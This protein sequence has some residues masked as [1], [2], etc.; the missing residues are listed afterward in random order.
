[1]THT[2]V[3]KL[4]IIGLWNCLTGAKPC[5]NI[6]TWTLRNKLYQRNRNSY[7]FIQG[8]YLKNAV[9]KLAA[10]CLGLYVSIASLM[11]HYCHIFC[12]NPITKDYY[13]DVLYTC[14]PWY[15]DTFGITVGL[16]IFPIISFMAY[17][18]VFIAVPRYA[19]FSSTKFRLSH[20][21]FSL[22]FVFISFAWN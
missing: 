22:L 15:C 13:Y 21:I 18:N 19:A 8:I 6:I 16:F 5:W 1:M 10:I 17:G 3:S 4:A 9:W 14:V 11:G 7:I 2:C 12:M 20:A